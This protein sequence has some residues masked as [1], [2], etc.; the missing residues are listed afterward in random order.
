MMGTTG[1]M[2]MMFPQLPNNAK[3]ESVQTGQKTAKTE[4]DIGPKEF[5]NM[6]YKKL[7]VY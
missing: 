7:D 4:P 2:Y 1:K 3:V 5:H 6:P